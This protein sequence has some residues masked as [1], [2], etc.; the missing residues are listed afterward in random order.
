M[1]PI[2][3]T[4]QAFGPYAGTQ[5]LDMEALGKTGI[6]A[7]TGE[8][9][10]GKTT[11][12]D[13]IVYALF[14]TGSGEDRPDG[15]GMRAVAAS[16]ALETRVE[17]SFVC[18]GKTYAIVRRPAQTLAGKRKETVD[19]AASQELTLPDGRVITK[20]DEIKERIEKDIL[21]VS[22]DQFCQIVMIV[23]GEFRK[24]L[25]A[26]T[27]ERTEIMRRIFKTE[28]F[29]ALGE[30][31]MVRCR[32][33]REELKS[34]RDLM[35]FSLTALRADPAS[36][37]DAQLK[38]LQAVAPEALLPEDAVGMADRIGEVDEAEHR[39]A[40]GELERAEQVRDAAREAHER[41]LGQQRMLKERAERLEELGALERR[42]DAAARTLQ[43]ARER[44][45]EAERLGREIITRQN[46]L[47]AYGRLD[48]LE[49][50]RAALG[51][52]LEKQDRLKKEAE[53][54]RARQAGIRDA[55]TAE[56]ESRKDAPDRRLRAKDA[57]NAARER[58]E[59]LEALNR[60]IAERD[61]AQQALAAQTVQAF[62]LW[63]YTKK[64]EAFRED[65]GERVSWD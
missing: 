14:G 9:G 64:L 62:M 50:T 61:S 58:G 27:T 19:R 10:A 23:Q 17:L 18:G 52:E 54:E 36:G 25:R 1:R 37:L 39:A 49:R 4:M 53:A 7:I 47:E 34:C 59:K 26:D 28:R 48:A 45:P 11:I 2:R 24:L 6:Y 63:R 33:K 22:K 29:N 21:G 41:A 56:A 43:E 32:E 42:S 30:R 46:Q 65:R 13:A 35:R 16:P 44:Q 15:K 55:L 57:L 8:T 12:F 3:L 31:A 20:N 51:G 40:A 5:V 60:R 38:A